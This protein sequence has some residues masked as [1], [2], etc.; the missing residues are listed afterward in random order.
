MR[1]LVKPKRGVSE[2]KVLDKASRGR[3]KK[4]GQVRDILILD[5]PERAVA[6]ILKN[7]K[8]DIEFAEEDKLEPLE[9]PPEVTQRSIW[10][11]NAMNMED[12]WKVSKGD[13]TKIAIL[14]TG[15]FSQHEFLKDNMLPGWNSVRQ[16]SDWS[17]VN[18]HGTAVAGASVGVAPECKIIPI[19]VSDLEDGAA[20]NSDMARALIWAAD[21][22]AE[23]ANMSYRSWTSLTVQD[24]A[25]YAVSKTGMFITGSAGNDGMEL[26]YA[27]NSNIAVVSATQEDG[28]IVWWSDYGRAVDIGAPGVSIYTSSNTGGYEYAYG[29]SFSSPIVAGLGALIWKRTSLQDLR[30]KMMITNRWNPFTGWG[31]AD[32]RRIVRPARPHIVNIEKEIQDD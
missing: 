5:L 4:I 21:N 28:S 25:S 22:G 3:G 13:G 23:V 6:A 24:A 7:M 17:D 14:D 15:V 30:M 32:A 2:Q 27:A 11:L 20:Y 18:G 16:N 31:T 8:D 1:I 9:K 19:R 29:T 12:A 26:P 10:H